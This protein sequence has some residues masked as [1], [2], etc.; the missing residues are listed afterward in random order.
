MAPGKRFQHRITTGRFTLPVVLCIS[1]GCWVLLSLFVSGRNEGQGGASFWGTL[2]GYLPRSVDQG[3]SWLL[4]TLIGYILIGINNA[5]SIIRVRASVQTS[6]FLM[7][8]AVCNPLHRLSEGVFAALFTLLSLIFLFRSYQKE[9]PQGDLFHSFLMLGVACF[10]VPEF[11][12]L[13]LVLLWGA[14]S[15][16]SLGPRSFFAAVVGWSLPWWFLFGHTYFHSNMELFTTPFLQMVSFE[17]LA[18]PEVDIRVLSMTGYIVFLWIIGSVHCAMTG[19]QEKIR[20]RTFLSFLILMSFFVW[21][22]QLL[23]PGDFM[24]FLPLGMV[25]SAFVVGHFFAVTDS[26]SSNWLFRFSVAGI[27]A[28]LVLNI[29]ML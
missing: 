27:L 13:S 20:T 16:Q 24:A 29:W 12:F 5:F 6:L 15:F 10:F 28:F 11:V 18:F 17:P 22:Y 1:I 4:Y 25:L 14:W 2:F 7:W 26:K 21:L 23:Q 9:R 8:V 3:L 19:Y